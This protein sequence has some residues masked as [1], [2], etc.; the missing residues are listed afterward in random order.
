MCGNDVQRALK[1]V[2][3]SYNNLCPILAWFIRSAIVSISNAIAYFS[4][5]PKL[6]YVIVPSINILSKNILD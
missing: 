5:L 4:I 1:P 2:D 6:A 3:R